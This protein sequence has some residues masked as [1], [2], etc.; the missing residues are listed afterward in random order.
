[1]T[2][3]EVVEWLGLT[4]IIGDRV[5]IPDIAEAMAE[6][7]VPTTGEGEIAAFAVLL[8]A[9]HDSPTAKILWD[10]ICIHRGIIKPEEAP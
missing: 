9:T 5:L 2:E 4:D 1:M 7:P 8:H 6:V 10:S 3:A